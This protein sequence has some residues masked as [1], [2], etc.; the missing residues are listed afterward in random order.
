MIRLL[1][2]EL[3]IVLWP[4]PDIRN[5]NMCNVN[6]PHFQALPVD[7]AAQPGLAR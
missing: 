2:N 6:G 5:H 4:T 3:L 1:L 7:I